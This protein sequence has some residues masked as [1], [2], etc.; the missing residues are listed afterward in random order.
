MIVA[1]AL[2]LPPLFTF[3]INNWQNISLSLLGFFASIALGVGMTLIKR[4]RDGRS[5]RQ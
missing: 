5:R 2:D 4:S 3:V 1:L